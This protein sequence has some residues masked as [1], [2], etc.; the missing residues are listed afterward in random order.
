MGCLCNQRPIKLTPSAVLERWRVSLPRPPLAFP[1]GLRLGSLS[2]THLF[3]SSS[4]EAY[5]LGEVEG[6]HPIPA[7]F[8]GEASG[9]IHYKRLQDMNLT[10]DGRRGFHPTSLHRPGKY[11]TFQRTAFHG[12]LLEEATRAWFPWVCSPVG[13]GRP[14]GTETQAAAAIQWSAR[15]K[16]VHHFQVPPNP[17]RIFRA[18]MIWLR[19]RWIRAEDSGWGLG[20]RCDPFTGKDP[21]T[22]IIRTGHLCRLLIISGIAINNHCNETETMFR[23]QSKLC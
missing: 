2:N 7:S 23:V 14:V 6:E 1:G 3:R 20:E 18:I 12:Q 5:P 4:K 16:K 19:S 17:H 13:K 21:P 15:G 10:S 11:S 8:I 9:A 22:P